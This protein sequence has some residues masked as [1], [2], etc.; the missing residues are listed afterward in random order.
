MHMKAFSPYLP[1]AIP[2]RAFKQRV[3]SNRH[4][5]YWVREGW[6][7]ENVG[8]GFVAVEGEGVEVRLPRLEGGIAC[9]VEG[10]G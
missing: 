6:F 7:A 9:F 3:L 10:G 8:E 1:A 4:R 2:F 5:S